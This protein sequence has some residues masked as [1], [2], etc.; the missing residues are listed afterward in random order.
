M[1]DAAYASKFSVGGS[2]DVCDMLVHDCVRWD[3]DP[4]TS[5]LNNEWNVRVTK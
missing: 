5:C 4:E 3:C 2:S 1:V